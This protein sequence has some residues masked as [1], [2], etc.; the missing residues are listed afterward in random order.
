MPDADVYATLRSTA[1]RLARTGG[2]MAADRLGQAI[3]GKKADQSFITQV[4]FE[5]QN[6]LLDVIAAELPEHAVLVEEEL[7]DPDRHAPIDRAEYCW[8][9][10]PLDGTRNFSRSFPVFSTS[11]AVVHESRPVV[12]AVCHAITGDVFAASAGQGATLN[13]RPVTVRDD[14]P[15]RDTMIFLRGRSGAPMPPPFHRWIDRF[16]LRN[17]GSGVLHLA[18]VAGGIVDA[19]CH[20]Q[21]KLWDLAAG[22]LLVTEAGGVVTRT[23][24]E[25]PFP[26]NLADYHDEDVDFLAAS[27]DLHAHLLADM[28][29]G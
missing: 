12:G 14:P 13:D 16:A 25:P 15:T 6:A 4:D 7:P 29:A 20:A 10:D 21:C 3:T 22:T 19:A 26:C 17:F 5:I 1:V 18:Y 2:R 11:V 23:S 9:I 8:V 27:P 28:Q 24:G